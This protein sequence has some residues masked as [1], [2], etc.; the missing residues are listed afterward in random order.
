MRSFLGNHVVVPTGEQL[1]GDMLVGVSTRV[2][3]ARMRE[4]SSWFGHPPF[5]LPRR[6]LAE[7]DRSVTHEPPLHLYLQRLA[8][9]SMRF[10]LPAL[11]AVLALLWFEL[12][13]PKGILFAPLVTIGAGLCLLLVVLA[14]KWLLL[15]RVRPGQHGLWSGWCQRWDFLYMAWGMLGRGVL[16]VFEGTLL[17]AWYLRAMGMR[18]GRRVVLAG[19]FAQ[20]VDPDMLELRDESCVEPLFQAHTFEDR[21][22][23]IGRVRIGEGATVRRGSVLFYGA[24]LGQGCQVAPHS[25][26]MKNERLLPGRHYRGCPT[27]PDSSGA[28]EL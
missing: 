7:M 6:E 20:V 18:I 26:V 22:L 21:V 10:L 4:G 5:E 16:G 12:V 1:A 13:T 23:K 15:G 9:E 2:D 8:W 24:E 28:R 14:L 3:G 27:R 11:L 17:L 25:V 19:S